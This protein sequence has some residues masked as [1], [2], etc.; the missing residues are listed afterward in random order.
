MSCYFRGVYLV[1]E[2]L[3]RNGVHFADVLRS[4]R[5]NSDEEKELPLCYRC[6]RTVFMNQLLEETT[7]RES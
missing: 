3:E 4:L 2:V 1:I 7:E 6:V 5:K